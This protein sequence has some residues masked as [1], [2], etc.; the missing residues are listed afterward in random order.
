METTGAANQT[1]AQMSVIMTG[2][3]QHGTDNIGAVEE[4][5]QMQLGWSLA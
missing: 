1:A 5:D 2:V 4:E 3:G